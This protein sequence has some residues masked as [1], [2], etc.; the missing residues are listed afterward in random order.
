MRTASQ[1]ILHLTD[2][3]F[4]CDNGANEVA[5]R[6]LALRGLLTALNSVEPDWKPTILCLTGDIGWKGLAGDYEQAQKWLKALIDKFGISEDRVLL[7]AGNHD[8]DRN[9]SQKYA[10]PKD[11]P[12]ADRILATPIASM[13][14]E[15]F[16][17]FC[18]FAK[19]FSIPPYAFGSE[20]S[21]LTGERVIEGISFCALNSAWFCQGPD[22]KGN[23]WLGK[24]HIDILEHS[25]QLSVVAG[26]SPT[27]ASLSE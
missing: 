17:P 12:E 5:A 13:Y 16:G 21:H 10:R 25:G 7:C 1:I 2:L 23:L 4:G 8:I 11:G 3:H 20:P 27:F 18:R 9:V 19:D 6:A 14:K 22:D 15:A 24:P 26:T